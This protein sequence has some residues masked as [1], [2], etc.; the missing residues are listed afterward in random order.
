MVVTVVDGG[1]ALERCLD[2]LS[3]QE[4]SPVLEVLVPCDDSLEITG[5]VSRHPRARLI[6][7]GRVGTAR[8]TATAGGQ[9][10]LYDRRRSAGLAQARGNLVAIVEDRGVPDP[11]W[12]R[13]F[14]AL[15]ARL[16]H[17]A[18]GG[19]V[20]NARDPVLN[21]AVFLC[22]FGR[23]APP[24][25]AGPRD[26]VTDV[27]VCYKRA[28][29]ERTETLWR[30]RYHE[31]EVHGALRRE[32]AILWLSPE[33]VV[34]QARDGLTLGRLLG[35]RFA[36][37]RLFA[38][39][40]ARESSVAERGARLFL[41]PLLPIVMGWRIVRGAAARGETGPALGALPAV[42][43]LLTAWAFGEAAGYLT[44]RD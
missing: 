37:G 16:P 30:E 14:A 13:A 1:A 7:L 10:E 20:A 42:L 12:A 15:H 21:R 3:R 29:L 5:I 6:P 25:E 39:V 28:A 31:T 43:L 40:R 44:G 38:A 19:A 8:P 4:G 18:I 35:E 24:F 23:Y 33:P 22:D 9:H 26:Y 27:N 17:P 41:A 36:W 32:G 2:A 34:R 11:G